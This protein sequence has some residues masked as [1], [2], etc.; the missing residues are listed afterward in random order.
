MLSGR[1]EW[2]SITPEPER[3]LPRAIATLRAGA[4]PPAGAVERERKRAERLVL[5][6]SRRSWLAWLA[7]AEEL[8]NRVAVDGR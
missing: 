2:L 6:G 1:R 3:V 4:A 8:A 5:H 7:E